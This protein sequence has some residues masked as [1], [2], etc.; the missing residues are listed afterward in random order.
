[1][2][3]GVMK[4]FNWRGPV[5]YG[6]LWPRPSLATTFF[7]HDLLWQRPGRLWP[8]PSTWPI[9]AI[10]VGTDR[11]WPTL[12]TRLGL[13]DFGAPGRWDALSLGY[14]NLLWGHKMLLFGTQKM[15]LT[16]SE[17]KGVSTYC[18]IVLDILEGPKRQGWSSTVGDPKS[19]RKSSRKERHTKQEKQHKEAEA[20]KYSSTN[21]ES[22]K[23][24]RK[25]KQQ[26]K[27]HK[28][29]KQQRKQQK[30]QQR[31]EGPEGGAPKVSLCS[32]WRLLVEFR[33]FLVFFEIPVNFIMIGY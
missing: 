16:L 21:K 19:S 3:Y 31:H 30:Q 26:Q 14:K 27:L 23:N 33:F 6:H 24:N 20:A 28:Q 4:K 25:H 32:H 12:P 11:F 15:L 8:Q 18:L 7:G 17:V 10:L 1:M 29:Y 22:S 13:A 9:W 5:G 2:W